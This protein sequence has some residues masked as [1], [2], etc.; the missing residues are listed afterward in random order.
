MKI[1]RNQIQTIAEIVLEVAKAVNE[2]LN[3]KNQK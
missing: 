1:D 2:Y 3:K